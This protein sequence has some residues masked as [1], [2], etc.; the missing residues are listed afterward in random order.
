LYAF[1]AALFGMI[2]AA[3]LGILRNGHDHVIQNIKERQKEQQWRSY[4]LP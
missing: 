4:M 2:P 1:T 3:I